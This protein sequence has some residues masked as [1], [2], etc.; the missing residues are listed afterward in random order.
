M[1]KDFENIKK[2]KWLKWDQRENIL[3]SKKEHLWIES[4]S[5]KKHC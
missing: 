4:S 1:R 2:E 5:M 3:Q